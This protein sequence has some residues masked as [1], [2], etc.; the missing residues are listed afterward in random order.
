[1]DSGEIARLKEEVDELK[2]TNEILFGLGWPRERRRDIAIGVAFF[3]VGAFGVG[4]LLNHGLTWYNAI[5][6]GV[7][8]LAYRNVSAKEKLTLRFRDEYRK[9]SAKLDVLKEKYDAATY[10]PRSPEESERMWREMMVE[11]EEQAKPKH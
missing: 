10:V 7:A 2:K 4:D 1:M 3:C 9:A 6:I 11:L 5:A 8:A